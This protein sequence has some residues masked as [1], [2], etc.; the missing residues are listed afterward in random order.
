MK[1]ESQTQT[2]LLSTSPSWNLSLGTFLGTSL[3]EPLSW[4]LFIETSFLE[5]LSWNLFLE[6]HLEPF[7]E[8]LL[9]PLLKRL[10]TVPRGNPETTLEGAAP[11]IWR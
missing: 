7:L 2:F 10:L 4:N 9:E 6:P 8:P 3:L 1:E 11:E 5:P